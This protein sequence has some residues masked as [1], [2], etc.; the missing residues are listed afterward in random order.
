[1]TVAPW[2]S[3]PMGLAQNTRLAGSA[4]CARF[5]K[6]GAD[7]HGACGRA[8]AEQ[9]GRGLQAP[10]RAPGSASAKSLYARFVPT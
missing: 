7:R 1:M 2:A 8:A 4:R 10:C 3:V 6:P 5:A 9:R